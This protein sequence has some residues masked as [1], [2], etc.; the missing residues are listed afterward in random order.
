MI[1]SEVHSFMRTAAQGSGGFKD[2]DLVE[3]ENKIRSKLTGGTPKRMT[4]ATEKRAQIEGDEWGRLYA[5]NVAE[6]HAAMRAEE[7]ARR[8]KQRAQ[9]ALYD[10]QIAEAAAAVAA[11]KAADAAYARQETAALA[12][13]DRRE[14]AKAAAKAAAVA[15][16]GQQRMA[17]LA[18]TNARRAGARQSH[19]VGERELAERIAWETKEDLNR[20]E[21]RMR[22]AKVQLKATLLGNEANRT[23]REDARQRTFAENTDFQRQWIAKLD[24]FDADRRVALD[25]VLAKQAAQA[26]IAAGRPESK[27]WINPAIIERNFREH[28]AALDTEEARRKDDAARRGAETAAAQLSQMAEKH[29]RR[30]VDQA[31]DRA[32]ATKVVADVEAWRREGRAA[33]ERKMQGRATFR[34]HIDGQ[35]K[36]NAHARRNAPMSEIER[37]INIVRLDNVRDFFA[38]GKLPAVPA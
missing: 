15:H 22:E 17:Q 6:G 10:G 19:A 36:A 2:E 12:E 4:R 8:E 27:R 29:A 26:E 23:T 11:G 13:A 30:A 35:L 38:T 32:H 21:G 34:A 20:E 33:E 24:K 18:D 3:L 28:E 31:A 14:A 16:L 25:R 7:V 9:R 5:Y 1:N 37:K